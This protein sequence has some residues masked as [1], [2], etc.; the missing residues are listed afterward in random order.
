MM[1]QT[2]EKSDLPKAIGPY[3]I[4]ESLGRGGMGEVFLAKDP[5]CGRHVALKRIRPELQLNKTI[6][7]RFLREAKVA[8]V[9]THPSIVPIFAIQTGAPDIYYTMPFVEGETLRQILRT[10]REQEKNG[11]PLHPIGSS[12]PALARIFLQVCEAVAY[13]HSKGIIHRDL[14]PENIIVGKYGEVMILDW[15]IAD[16]IDQIEK[17]EPISIK[18]APEKK[19]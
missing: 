7:S 12:I 15:G 13:T 8:S 16:F 17:E 19:I 2:E 9:L 10:T 4:V 11:D 3:A 18:R 1:E 14:K 6:Q 5:I